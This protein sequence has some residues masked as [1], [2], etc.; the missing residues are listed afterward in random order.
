LGFEQ[1]SLKREN[2]GSGCLKREKTGKT[3][4]QAA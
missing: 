4:F 1:G 3:G 2:G